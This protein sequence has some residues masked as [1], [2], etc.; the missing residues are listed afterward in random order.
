MGP[1]DTA[2]FIEG[3]ILGLDSNIEDIECIPTDAPFI[4]TLHDAYG[5]MYEGFLVWSVPKIEEGLST[6]AKGVQEIGAF[7]KQSEVA[8]HH[9]CD[10]IEKL[11]SD[12]K[13]W[14]GIL[15]VTKEE[16]VT[17]WHHRDDITKDVNNFMKY[18]S[19]SKFELAGVQAGRIVAILLAGVDKQWVLVDDGD[20]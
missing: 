10:A 1:S 11:C 12:F 8:E 3:F 14:S 6:F 5:Q 15:M 2:R 18:W 17:I 16:I 19:S 7:L 9:I 20:L 4:D 13:T